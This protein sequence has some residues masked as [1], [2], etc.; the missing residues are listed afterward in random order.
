MNLPTES[1]IRSSK[2]SI[3]NF[4]SQSGHR[5]DK[6]KH[7]KYGYQFF[8][9]LIISIALPIIWFYLSNNFWLSIYLMMTCF[10]NLEWKWKLL[11]FLSI[12]VPTYSSIT[13]S[14]SPPSHIFPIS[15][16][17]Y[18]SPA[19]FIYLC[20]FFSLFLPFLTLSFPS[21]PSSLSSSLCLYLFPFL[22]LAMDWIARPMS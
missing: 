15:P 1:I 20:F 10:P 7:W 8:S 4:I 11:L 17:F 19:L 5:L 21:F 16:S 12:Y 9:F 22:S 13:L 3:T 6:K 18:L 14:F 2:P